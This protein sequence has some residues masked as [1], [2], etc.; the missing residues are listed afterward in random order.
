MMFKYVKDEFSNLLKNAINGDNLIE[1][2][3][4]ENNSEL[5]KVLGRT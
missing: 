3:V 2:E 4:E 5:D 1:V